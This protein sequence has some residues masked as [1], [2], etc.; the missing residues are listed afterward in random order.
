MTMRDYDVDGDAMGA[1][2]WTVAL[3]SLALATALLWPVW[4]A[5]SRLLAAVGGW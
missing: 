3:V 2:T 1:T 4:V 5:V